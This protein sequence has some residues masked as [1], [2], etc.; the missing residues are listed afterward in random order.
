MNF[1]DQS[2]WLA[3][4]KY[5]IVK[6]LTPIVSLRLTKSTLIIPQ[7]RKDQLEITEETA[8]VAGSRFMNAVKS[9]VRQT[10]STLS[11]AQQTKCTLRLPSP[12]E[13]TDWFNLLE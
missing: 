6:S 1:D 12:S 10:K 3:E 4:R 8:A 11:G 5:G 7:M 9:G 2:T 13:A